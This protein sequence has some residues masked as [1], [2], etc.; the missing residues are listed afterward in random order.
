MVVN[1]DYVYHAFLRRRFVPRLQL[2]TTE[3]LLTND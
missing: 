3:Q 2:M 1:H